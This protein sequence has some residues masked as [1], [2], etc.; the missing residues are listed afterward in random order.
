MR[1]LVLFLDIVDPLT[2]RVFVSDRETRDTGVF[3]SDNQ[4]QAEGPLKRAGRWID[5]HLPNDFTG[6]SDVV[7]QG[8]KEGHADEDIGSDVGGLHQRLTV[9]SVS[10]CVGGCTPRSMA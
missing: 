3:A 6:E 10:V 1:L 4:C 5:S 7:E 2:I 9:L 8:D